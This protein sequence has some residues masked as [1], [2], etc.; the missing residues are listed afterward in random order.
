MRIFELSNTIAGY[1]DR[2]WSRRVLIITY[3][4]YFCKTFL[5]TIAIINFSVG[6]VTFSV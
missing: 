6:Q 2:K 1:S 3:A 5:V 4:K